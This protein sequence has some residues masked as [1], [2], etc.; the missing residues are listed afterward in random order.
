M[1]E[2]FISGGI[3]YIK[4]MCFKINNSGYLLISLQSVQSVMKADIISLNTLLFDTSI[5]SD[6]PNHWWN[7]M[8]FY[9]AQN[10]N[11]ANNKCRKQY[12]KAIELKSTSEVIF[13][14]YTRQNSEK[15]VYFEP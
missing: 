15:I 8:N 13:N 12:A 6:Q 9:G 14:F 7:Q 11:S 1:I 5:G 10:D 2:L 4:N 3:I